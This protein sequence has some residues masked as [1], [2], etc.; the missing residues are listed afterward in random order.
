[1]YSCSVTRD[2]TMAEELKF[3]ILL[4]RVKFHPYSLYL[5]LLEHLSWLIIYPQLATLLAESKMTLFTI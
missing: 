3:R 5:L 4:K 2:S 1:M